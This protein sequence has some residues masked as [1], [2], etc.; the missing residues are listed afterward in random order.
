MSSFKDNFGR[1]WQVRIDCNALRAILNATGVNL[2]DMA[3]ISQNLA[4][5]HLD[6]LFL[7]EAAWSLVKDQPNAI[8]L[9]LTEFMANMRLEALVSAER[10][11]LEGL[12][13]FFPLATVREAVADLLAKTTP[14][15]SSS[16]SQASSGSIPDPSPLPS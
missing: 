2:G 11:I 7:G 3:S 9:G 8:T 13:A 12:T 15:N 5:L 16:N 4:R 10:A 14:G 1:E 6:A